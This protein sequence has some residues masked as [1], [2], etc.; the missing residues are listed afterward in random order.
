V[1]GV[2]GLQSLNTDRGQA[3]TFNVCGMIAI[4]GLYL[5]I[6]FTP[7]TMGKHLVEESPES[8]PNKPGY[9]EIVAENGGVEVAGDDDDYNEVIIQSN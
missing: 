9:E 1:V 2:W 4:L 7:E 8:K 6:Y 3:E 5:T